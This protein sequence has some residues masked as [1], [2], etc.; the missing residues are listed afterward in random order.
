MS[1]QG[2]ERAG[3]D[4]PVLGESSP[5]TDRLK[6]SSADADGKN[7]GGSVAAI[8]TLATAR[9]LRDR[10][11]CL[12]MAL[13]PPLASSSG[14]RADCRSGHAARSSRSQHPAAPRGRSHL[15]AAPARARSYCF[16]CS[17]ETSL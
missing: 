12:P 6:S 16:A 1:Q 2:E 17:G 3:S 9:D 11:H 8:S 15:P 4:R 7:K 14:H 13:L 10:A 5:G